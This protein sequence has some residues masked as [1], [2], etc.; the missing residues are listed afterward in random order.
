MKDLTGFTG[1]GYDKGRPQVVL[2][3]WLAVQG[4]VLQH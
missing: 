2:A 1:V 4:A 3:A